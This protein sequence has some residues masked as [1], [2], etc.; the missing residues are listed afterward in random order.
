MYSASVLLRPRQGTN[1][2]LANGPGMHDATPGVGE[3]E[4]IDAVFKPDFGN[5]VVLI[6]N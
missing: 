1:R 5:I 3:K 4:I 6:S 2:D